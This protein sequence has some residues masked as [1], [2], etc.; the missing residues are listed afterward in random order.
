[1]GSWIACLTV[2]AALRQLLEDAELVK[3]AN[4]FD[5]TSIRDQIN[6]KNNK[7]ETALDIVDESSVSIL[8]AMG[9]DVSLKDEN[10]TASDLTQP[11]GTCVKL[12]ERMRVSDS[13]QSQGDMEYGWTAL[14]VAAEIG[15]IEQIDLLQEIDINAKN[16]RRQTALMI[17]ASNANH[18]EVKLLVAMK[19]NLEEKDAENQQTALCCAAKSGCVNSIGILVEAKADL[20]VLCKAD[21]SSVKADK[22]VL[23]LASENECIELLREYGVDG[24]TPLMIAIERGPY[25]AKLFQQTRDTLI[26]MR[27]RQSFP[28]DFQTSLMLYSKL[29]D[30][31]KSWRWGM[32]E[33]INLVMSEDGRT[34]W[35]VTDSPDYSCVIGD[36]SFKIGVHRWTLKGKEVSCMWAGVAHCLT[37]EHLSTSPGGYGSGP[38]IGFQCKGNEVR[39]Y[40]ENA[41]EITLFSKVR[42]SSTRDQTL[43]FELDMYDRSLKIWVDGVLAVVVSNLTERELQPYVCM[44][45]NESVEL[46]AC[47]SYDG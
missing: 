44:D 28:T 34:V 26:C 33:P 39:I 17:A 35:K 37:K 2:I 1:M 29:R 3:E 36:S 12:L 21:V 13:S 42:Y 11:E 25:C 31:Q 30:Q 8:L 9:A 7:F 32:R 5:I 18:K 6:V 20:T 41:A 4:V 46:V 38:C 47:T 19:S 14:M 23:D 22:T 27:Q 10:K 45:D 15:Y 16:S 43:D 40:G 24:W